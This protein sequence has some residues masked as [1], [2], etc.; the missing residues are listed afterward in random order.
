MW[1]VLEIKRT[2]RFALF[3]WK[4][5]QKSHSHPA[6]VQDARGG[7]LVFLFF[8]DATQE[9]GAKRLPMPGKSEHSWTKIL[10][11]ISISDSPS[12][13]AELT[14][15]QIH[16]LLTNWSCEIWRF[17]WSRLAQITVSTF[18][19]GCWKRL[20]CWGRMRSC[21]IFKLNPSWDEKHFRES[22]NFQKDLWNTH[23]SK[24]GTICET[25]TSQVSSFHRP[26]LHRVWLPSLRR[27]DKL[28]CEPWQSRCNWQQHL[29][30]LHK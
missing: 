4:G 20:W 5:S 7:S 2:N 3:V 13:Y 27:D 21:R 22:E 17:S 16:W 6:I 28:L 14:A 15:P 1:V 25:K 23:T 18:R 8:S 29:Q 9:F 30:S 24:G 12:T 19:N 26:D 10:A 11:K